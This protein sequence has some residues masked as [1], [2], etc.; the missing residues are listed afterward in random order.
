[1]IAFLEGKVAA[2]GAEWVVLAVSGVGFRLWIPLSTRTRLPE[3]GQPFRLETRLVWREDG[4]AL[5]GFATQP[6]AEL[7]DLLL[8]VSGVG[9]RLALSA[10]SASSPPALLE[11]LALQDVEALRRIPGVGRKT[12]ERMVLELK[13]K[14]SLPAAADAFRPAAGV[15]E[16]AAG[17]VGQAVQALQVL[18]YSRAE[19]MLAVEA[20]TR[21]SAAEPGTGAG[22]EHLI[23]RALQY[24][25]A[26]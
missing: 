4:P 2:A 12:A 5:Y 9:P 15:G 25:A 22:A 26:R 20:V 23:R 7:F 21:E 13:D 14:V 8:R 16:A 3:A 24:L 17:A 1:M 11:A 18:G 19:A 6:E 10:L